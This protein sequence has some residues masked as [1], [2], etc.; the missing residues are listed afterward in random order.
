MRD[1]LGI[2]AWLVRNTA[3]AL[4]LALAVTTDMT[5]HFLRRPAARDVVA[6]GRL[7]RLGRR[8]AVGEVS[9]RSDGEA[10]AICHVVG[11]YAIP[12]QADRRRDVDSGPRSP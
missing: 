10:G 8:L 9:M 5:I 12:S 3:Q 7:L 6:E 4:I 11:T 2:P 1:A